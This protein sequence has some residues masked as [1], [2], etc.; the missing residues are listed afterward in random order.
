MIRRPPRSTRTDTLFPYT[1]LFRSVEV[2]HQALG[3]LA[4]RPTVHAD[5]LRVGRS[6]GEVEHQVVGHRERRDQPVALAVLGDVRDPELDH[7]SRVGE[8]DVGH[9][10]LAASRG[11]PP[12][13]DDGLPTTGLA[14]ALHTAPA[15]D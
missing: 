1:T 2:A 15:T 5:A 13:A 7:A 8:G 10:Q 3:V 4:D 6:P 9:V 11:G 14:G 12:A